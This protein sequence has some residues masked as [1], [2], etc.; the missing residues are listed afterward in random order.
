MPVRDAPISAG[1][2]SEVTRN[3]CAVAE[4]KP[5]RRGDALVL[6]PQT[7]SGENLVKGFQ[8]ERG[9]TPVLLMS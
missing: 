4:C 6:Y 9:A 5:A 3:A 8:V 1:R 2:V 7:V